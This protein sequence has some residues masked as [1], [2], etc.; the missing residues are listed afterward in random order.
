MALTMDYSLKL[1]YTLGRH[2]NVENFINKLSAEQV[3]DFNTSIE[4]Q[5]I[6]ESTYCK[7]TLLNGN[8]DNLEIILSIYKDAEKQVIIENKSYFFVP[9]IEVGAE[10]FIKQGY[11]Y[12]KTLPEY[13]YAIDC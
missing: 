7:I 5:F 10:N 3:K 4:K 1:N 12:L 8:K 11:E 9:N 13:A 2:T 6:L